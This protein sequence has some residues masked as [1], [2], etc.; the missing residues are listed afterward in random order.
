MHRCYVHLHWFSWNQY[1]SES[2]SRT[3]FSSFYSLLFLLTILSSSASTWDFS[4]LIF[5]L[6]LCIQRRCTEHQQTDNNNK[7]LICLCLHI[8][9]WKKMWQIPRALILSCRFYRMIAV[10]ICAICVHF[11]VRI[12]YTETKTSINWCM[13][14]QNRYAHPPTRERHEK[15][16]FK[17]ERN[18]FRHKNKNKRQRTRFIHFIYKKTF[19]TNIYKSIQSQS[20]NNIKWKMINRH[21]KSSTV[22]QTI[23]NESELIKKSC[24]NVTRH[25]RVHVFAFFRLYWKAKSS[26]DSK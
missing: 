7:T 15:I 10:C 6:S 24:S 5:H 18:R 19:D 26:G 8:S 17:Q 16:K 14:H 3:F 25:L 20:Y 21:G 2:F 1:K 12:Q 11:S 23:P 22:M 13:C 9:S 4:Y